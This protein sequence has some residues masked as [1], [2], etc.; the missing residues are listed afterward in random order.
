MFQLFVFSNKLW[1]N[2]QLRSFLYILY[3]HK[4]ARNAFLPVCPS[5]VKNF[6]PSGTL[7]TTWALLPYVGSSASEAVTFITDVPV[8]KTC[9]NVKTEQNIFEWDHWENLRRAL[10]FTSV[11]VIW[12][13]RCLREAMNSPNVY[14]RLIHA[15]VKQH[16]IQTKN[17]LKF[18]QLGCSTKSSS[19]CFH[20]HLNTR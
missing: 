18:C 13:N 7:Y 20:L 2:W 19:L 3:S 17:S 5:T 4:A 11:H 12:M 1:L 8:E 14:S 15:W 9:Q 16:I 10:E 6:S